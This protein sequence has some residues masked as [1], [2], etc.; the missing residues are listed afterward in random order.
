MNESDNF[1]LVPMAPG[2][3][4]K[5]QLGA[6]RI[7]SGMVAD[8]L[9]LAKKEPSAK[10]VFTA[11]LGKDHFADLYRLLLKSQLGEQYDLNIIQFESAT[12]L[13][14]LAEEHAF[15]FVAVYLLN[16]VW[17]AGVYSDM[18]CADAA[19]GKWNFS[20]AHEVLGRLYS[21]YG[22]P[23]FATQGLELT[24][25]FEGTGVAFVTA[26]FEI[27]AFRNVIKASLA[28]RQ[29]RKIVLVDDDRTLLEI[30]EAVI[31]RWLNEVTLRV[32]DNGEEAWRELLRAAP[33]LLITDMNRPGLNGWKM[34]PLLTERKA[35]Y[36][37]LVTSGS[38]SEELV[39][40][41]ANKGLNVTFL[42]KPFAWRKF[43]QI[44]SSKLGLGD[45]PDTVVRKNNR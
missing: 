32:F 42:P 45:Q 44:L 18:V 30:V 37:I 7:L 4:E 13:L 28:L 3:I 39:L 14:K 36:P 23:I 24:K 11:L 21:S 34:L 25:E 5:A 26:P 29:P 6:K 10:P 2:A 16:I 41:Y 19:W 38:K 20:R 17:D 33:D 22:K 15:D 35:K 12:E 40:E 8:T 27:E 1:A 9:A 31:R 43:R